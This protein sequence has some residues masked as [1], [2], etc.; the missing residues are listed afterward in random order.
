MENTRIMRRWSLSMPLRATAVTELRTLVGVERGKTATSQY[1]P[2]ILHRDG[3]QMKTDKSALLKRLGP[4]RRKRSQ[5]Q[6]YAQICG[7]GLLVHSILSPS[8]IGASYASIARTMLS[9]V[10]SGRAED[11]HVCFHKCVENSIEYSERKQRGAVDTVYTITGPDQKIRQNGKILLKNG[12]ILLKNGT[13]LLKNGT[14][15]KQLVK[16]FM[17]VGKSN[18]WYVLRGKTLFASYGGERLQYVSGGQQ[19]ITVYS[20]LIFKAITKKLIR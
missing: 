7:G 10:C 18:Y 17:R 4:F 9:L 5:K 14:L 13:I 6:N 3:T 1:L 11:V 2:H 19:N 20:H 8:G 12:K 15:T 16:F